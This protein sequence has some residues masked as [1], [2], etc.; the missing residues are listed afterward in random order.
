MCNDCAFEAYCGA[1]PVFHHGR[2]KDF[3]GR[4]PE[5]EFCNRNMRIFKYVIERMEADPYVKRLF[6][7][8]A[9]PNA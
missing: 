6:M 1:D 4:K 5:S 3:I 8:W 7:S 9:Q 2:Y